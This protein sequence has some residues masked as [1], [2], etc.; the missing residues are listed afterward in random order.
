MHA[1]FY[2]LQGYLFPCSHTAL[3]ICIASKLFLHI[4]LEFGTHST[5]FPLLK[6]SF[7]HH[8]TWL[9]LFKN[10]N[11]PLSFWTFNCTYHLSSYAI[12][13]NSF[14]L[15]LFIPLKFFS[16]EKFLEVLISYLFY[17]IIIFILE[18]LK[19][20]QIHKENTNYQ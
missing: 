9:Q 18:N 5:G 13:R 16:F 14:I 17:K 10:H 20:S 1:L 8:P 7:C 15:D 2:M 4:H 12:S 6:P 11:L 3:H 19:K